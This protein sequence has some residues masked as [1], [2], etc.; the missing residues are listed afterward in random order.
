MKAAKTPR[1]Q[2]GAPAATP[3]R[4]AP[5]GPAERPWATER[6]GLYM[7]W[8]DDSAKKSA[9]VK[10]EEAVSAYVKHFNARP[11]VVLVN[12]SDR[13]EVAGVRVRS[14]SYVRRDNFWVGY[15]EAA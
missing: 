1:A 14:E 8:F 10:I 15:E 7:M 9:A 2:G 4:S 5:V 11:N 12:E 13:V 3:A 6:R